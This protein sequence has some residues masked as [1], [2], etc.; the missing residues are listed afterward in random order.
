MI[1]LPFLRRRLTLQQKAE[2]ASAL[3]VPTQAV[4]HVRAAKQR[5]LHNGLFA[6]LDPEA[7]ARVQAKFEA[8]E[9]A[10]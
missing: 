8:A 2:R 4:G 6:N 5:A 3:A 7:R 10:R 9:G 1:R